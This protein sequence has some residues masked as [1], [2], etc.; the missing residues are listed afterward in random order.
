MHIRFML[1]GVQTK[2]PAMVNCMFRPLRSG[3]TPKRRGQTEVYEC[4][5]TFTEEFMKLRD[6]DQPWIPTIKHDGT[7]CMILNGNLYARLDVRPGKSIKDPESSLPSSDGSFR[8]IPQM[9]STNAAYQYH[10]A[11][12]T[13][14]EDGVTAVRLVVPDQEQGYVIQLVPISELIGTY[15]LVGPKIQNNPYRFPEELVPVEVLSKGQV[16]TRK[17]PAHYLVRHGSFP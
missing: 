5:G 14:L 4:D 6:S 17:I 13:I 7:C 1:Q 11:S 10:R 2:I 8:W 15:E 12:L 9:G 16:T 3:E